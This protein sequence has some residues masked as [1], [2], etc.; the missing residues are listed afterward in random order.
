MNDDLSQDEDDDDDAPFSQFHHLLQLHPHMLMNLLARTTSDN[1]GPATTDERERLDSGAS[2]N[3][4]RSR[5]AVSCA[6]ICSYL[7]QLPFHLPPEIL[8]AIAERACEADV[9]AAAMCECE[10]ARQG[11][12]TLEWQSLDRSTP[13]Q[14]DAL[15][16]TCSRCGQARVARC[17][18]K[19]QEAGGGWF[20]LRCCTMTAGE[21]SFKPC[22]HFM[23][24]HPA[25]G[26]QDDRCAVRHRLSGL[27]SFRSIVASEW[28]IR[29]KVT[30]EVT[31]E[32]LRSLSSPVALS[33][34][35]V[36]AECEVNRDTG[37]AAGMRGWE[38]SWGFCVEEYPADD[39]D[40]SLHEIRAIDSR[41]KYGGKFEP[42]AGAWG[43][44]PQP[45]L[46]VQM[47]DVVFVS[48]DATA[49]T[50]GIEVVRGRSRVATS[51]LGRLEGS[52]PTAPLAL[53]VGLKY[54]NDGVCLRRVA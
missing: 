36:T 8:A 6:R 50:F 16:I 49:R 7:R 44:W 1:D 21:A 17:I 24:E 12:C 3:D 15:L 52:E 41:A 38:A 28:V 2:I 18:P 45:D 32:R 20:A 9:V 10:G 11:S 4:V 46:E 33:V 14:Q 47:G 25:T 35:C 27:H 51:T 5:L 26:Q 54:A 13:G 42:D 43:A 30:Y 37:W 34:G 22:R 39:D 19:V 48:I 23:R 40:P 53:C 29:G 31:L